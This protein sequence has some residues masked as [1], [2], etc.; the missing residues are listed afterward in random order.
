M[1]ASLRHIRRGF[2]LIELLVV[3]AI[4]ALLMAVL[5]PSLA[6][7]R[8]QAKRAVCL[9]NFQ[10]QGVG[11]NAYSGDHKQVLPVRGGF[12]YD[13]R[14]PAA[15]IWPRVKNIPR[16]YVNQAGL[17]G[18]YSGKD[19][20]FYYCPASVQFAY[21]R[22][23]NGAKS[24]LIDDEGAGV[25]NGSYMFA[26]PVPGGFYPRDDGRGWLLSRS[27][28]RVNCVTNPVA[29]DASGEDVQIGDRLGDPYMRRNTYGND[30][31]SMRAWGL[32]P[33]YGRVQALAV[34]TLIGSP[35]HKNA[36]GVLFQDYHARFV[37]DPPN[38]ENVTYNGQKK[39]AGVPLV[40][41]YASFSGSGQ[42]GA[43]W[44]CAAWNLL[45]S[46]P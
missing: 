17:Y 21:E 38:S 9:H 27:N 4:I 2:T 39:A 10:Q 14:E 19:L 46:K 42:T 33:Y 30:L 1:N 18:K 5:L 37:M 15:Y 36:Y 41:W 45:S 26:V 7:A 40:R 43:P 34:D 25:T 44:L 11:L 22:E 20:Y 16:L 3:V 29:A 24:F 28:T 13:L 23:S 35:S 6:K 31:K 32:Q 12:A 8:E